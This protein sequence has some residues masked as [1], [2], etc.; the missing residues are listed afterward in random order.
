MSIL[1]RLTYSLEVKLNMFLQAF[2]L[3]RRIEDLE[4]QVDALL[5][6]SSAKMKIRNRA[7]ITGHLIDTLMLMEQLGIPFKGH[8]DS[9]RLEPESDIKDIHAS[10][11]KLRTTL[12]LH[13]MGNSELAAH[14]KESPS[15]ATYINPD[16]QNE[17]ITL[18]GEE[19]SSSIS[20]K[21]KD[22]SY[23]AVIAD[24]TTDKSI[25]S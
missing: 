10:A 11:R 19:I 4:L 2:K 15:D 9:D 24:E 17:L 20:S 1:S 13:S 3:E 7:A 8:R 14:L 18:I 21:V 6:M 12:Q 16:I 5:E 25:K 22:A 23:F